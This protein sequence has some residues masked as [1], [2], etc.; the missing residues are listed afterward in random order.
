MLDGDIE[1]IQVLGWVK[2]LS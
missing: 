2:H 1:L